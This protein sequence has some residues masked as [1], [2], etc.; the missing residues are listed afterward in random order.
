MS[1][2]AKQ[3]TLQSNLHESQHK[4]NGVWGFEFCFIFFLLNFRSINSW[5]ELSFFYT[6]FFFLLFFF[7]ITQGLFLSHIFE[8]FF[9]SFFTLLFRMN[10]R[11]LLMGIKKWWLKCWTLTLG[12]FYVF[13]IHSLFFVVFN[14]VLNCKLCFAVWCSGYWSFFI[15]PS[16]FVQSKFNRTNFRNQTF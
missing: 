13:Y 11:L 3:H 10:F 4:V 8:V 15:N 9:P 1:E 12:G 2:F 5:V 6:I 14:N 16:V 7:F